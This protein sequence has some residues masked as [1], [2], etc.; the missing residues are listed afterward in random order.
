MMS[1]AA[2]WWLFAK[3]R[4]PPAAHGPMLAVFV[5]ANALVADGHVGSFTK[6]RIRD[7]HVYIN[8]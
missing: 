1:P 6:G 7:R 3:E 2:R 5:A 8:Y 4:F